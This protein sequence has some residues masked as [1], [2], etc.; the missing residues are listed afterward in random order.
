MMC[1][2]KSAKRVEFWEWSKKGQS[3][4]NFWFLLTLREFSRP[5]KIIVAQLFQNTETM[6]SLFLF[7]HLDK[8]PKYITLPSTMPNNNSVQAN[9]VAGRNLLELGRSEEITDET[10]PSAI[11]N[12]AMYSNVAQDVIRNPSRCRIRYLLGTTSQKSRCSSQMLHLTPR[13]KIKTTSICAPIC[14]TK[15]RRSFHLQHTNWR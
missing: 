8:F 13:M 1:W 10:K 5:E 2:Q 7:S 11:Y 3:G 9:C 6:Q 15:L 14:K 12:S 4:T